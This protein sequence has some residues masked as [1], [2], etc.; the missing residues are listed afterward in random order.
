ML[1]RIGNLHQTQKKERIKQNAI[2]PSSARRSWV[3][4]RTCYRGH[5]TI[6]IESWALSH[7]LS[8][9]AGEQALVSEGWHHWAKGCTLKSHLDPFA[10]DYTG[11]YSKLINDGHSVHVFPLISLS[12]YSKWTVFSINTHRSGSLLL[13]SLRLT[14]L[15]RGQ[16]VCSSHSSGKCEKHLKINGL[17]NFEHKLHL[18]PHIHQLPE[19]HKRK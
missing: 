1:K 19:E 16:W 3:S 2:K 7:N 18:A 4:E 15:L 6:K 12:N 5:R 8:D 13:F 9:S 11:F 17:G 10:I 14:N